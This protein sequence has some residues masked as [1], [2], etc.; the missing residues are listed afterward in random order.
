MS[1]SQGAEKEGTTPEIT[2]QEARCRK[3]TAGYVQAVNAVDPTRLLTPDSGWVRP[4]KQVRKLE[5][6]FADD[7]NLYTPNRYWDMHAYYGWHKPVS[8][9]W[10]TLSEVSNP[11]GR[12]RPFVLTEF[13][14]EAMPNWASYR[15]QPWQGVWVNTAVRP[16]GG[17]EAQAIGLPLRVLQES[18]CKLSQAYQ[19]FLYQSM[20]P[21]SAT[22]AGTDSSPALLPMAGGKVATTKVLSTCVILPNLGG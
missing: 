8:L 6:Y 15:D 14:S 17:L 18:E 16:S 22:K 21:P 10:E 9:L 3:I 2:T 1:F 12:Q 7:A 11:S 4:G 20:H 13:G 5:S 19:A